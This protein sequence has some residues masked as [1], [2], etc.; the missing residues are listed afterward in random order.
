MKQTLPVA[1]A[2]AAAY[3]DLFDG[4][5]IYIF[6][7]APPAAASDALDMVNTHCQVAVITLDDDGTTGL[8]WDSAA[9]GA[10]TKPVAVDW[11][12]T[13]FN[14]GFDD[15]TAT[16]TPT[17][18]RMGVGSDDCRGAGVGEPRLQWPVSGPNGNG[19]VVL[20]S[21][22]TTANGTNKVPVNLARIT[23]PQG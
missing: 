23:V 9:N 6:A 17:F 22:T 4:G 2:L 3:K 16:Q 5:K 10:V 20:G 1:T 12:G 8:T 14:D 21:P 19:E 7:G 15:A 18:A 11:S 13:V